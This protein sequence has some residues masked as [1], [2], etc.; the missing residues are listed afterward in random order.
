MA[1]LT[2]EIGSGKKKE[3]GKTEEEKEGLEDKGGERGEA[4]ERERK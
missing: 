4:Q 3:K 2:E 1:T